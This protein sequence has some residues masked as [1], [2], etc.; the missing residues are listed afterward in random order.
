MNPSSVITTTA[1]T[2]IAA[3]TPIQSTDSQIETPVNATDDTAT[4]QT[5]QT[6]NVIKGLIYFLSQGSTQPLWNY[7]DI[8]AKGMCCVFLRAVKNEDYRM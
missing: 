4:Q 8:T 6:A 7:E 1:A 5:M 3:N 2:V